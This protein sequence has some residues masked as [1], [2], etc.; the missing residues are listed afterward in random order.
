MKMKTVKQFSAFIMAAALAG[1]SIVSPVSAAEIS[2]TPVSAEWAGALA[3]GG[4]T[5]A[6]D[7]AELNSVHRTSANTSLSVMNSPSIVDNAGI[8]INDVDKSASA[9]GMPLMVCDVTGNNDKPVIGFSQAGVS[10]DWS[11]SWKVNGASRTP[12]STGGIELSGTGKFKVVANAVNSAGVTTS[13]SLYVVNLKSAPK[14]GSASIV[15]SAKAGI[16]FSTDLQENL[17]DTISV[18]NVSDSAKVTYWSKR[19]QN[20]SEAID[21]GSDGYV[22]GLPAAAGLYLVKASVAADL[23]RGYLP[24]ETAPVLITISRSTERISYGKMLV[25]SQ[26][27][28]HAESLPFNL[29]KY[30]TADDD[31][32][33]GRV[34]ISGSAAR[35]L[36][37]KP[38][39]GADGTLQFTLDDTA[40]F[41]QKSDITGRIEL[42]FPK[43]NNCSL[44]ASFDFII[45]PNSVVDLSVEQS[46]CEYGQLL[47]KPIAK[48]R[49]SG[50]ELGNDEVKYTYNAKGASRVT[51]TAPTAA[52]EY[53]IYADYAIGSGTNK[54]VG[55]AFDEFTI[56]KAPLH[57]SPDLSKYSG[58]VDASVLDAKIGYMVDAGDNLLNGDKFTVEPVYKIDSR[59]Y[60]GLEG[61]FAVVVSNKEAVLAGLT[62]AGSYEVEFDESQTVRVKDEGLVIKF[63]QDS[64][65]YGE[66]VSA[67]VVLNH[68]DVTSKSKISYTK[69]NVT[70]GITVIGAVSTDGLPSLPGNYTVTAQCG[71]DVAKKSLVIEKRA[72]TVS[73][74]GVTIKQGE[75]IPVIQ[76]T[77]DGLLHKEDLVKA[78]VFKVVSV[79]DKLTE[80]KSSAETGTWMICVGTEAV[81]KDADYF[82]VKYNTADFV[83]LP[84]D[85]LPGQPSL[86]DPSGSIADGVVDAT[87]GLD[88]I[89]RDAA[90]NPVVNR[91][92]KLPTGI[93]Y[94]TDSAGKM[95]TSKFVTTA[96]GS[97]Y[98]ATRAGAVAAGR[99]IA[100]KGKKYFCKDDGKIAKSEFCQTVMGSTVYAKSSGV[101]ACDATLTVKGKKYYAKKSCAL[102]KGTF[103]TTAKGSKVYAKSS[104]VLVTGKLFSV[105]G[106]Q[107]YAKKSGA[108]VKKKWIT[109]GK[110]KYYCNVYGRITKTKR[111]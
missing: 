53:V 37:D 36:V 83:I 33:E 46:G 103:V 24:Q 95:I 21:A 61:D 30:I 77:I 58:I 70:N 105:N 42:G 109:V 25:S 26:E 55:C 13:A 2:S 39:I 81:L 23:A 8:T 48:L 108:L 10:D 56:E 3:G 38:S 6:D 74:Q 51:S 66:T 29:G 67:T 35:M 98:Y 87:A 40:V 85:V 72:L 12:N 106:K 47:P 88:G 45:T 82:D 59:T 79:S 27:L 86:S 57:V 9:A 16:R 91:I 20:A 28:V 78:P 71:E 49:D 75:A 100:V 44:T 69:D 41:D 73:P 43:L 18:R 90:G 1:T 32:T 97:M 110:K 92:V 22:E 65:K 104:G 84:S 4:T 68:V 17:K 34:S 50:V 60:T 111:V 11:V 64:Y 96:D 99:I 107:Y 102:A 94:I 19:I 101:L 76:Y 14:S 31:L 7:M 62:N 52:G 15:S 54:V 89:F 93:K 80:L 5:A 63:G